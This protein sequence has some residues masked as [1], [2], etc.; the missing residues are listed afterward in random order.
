MAEIVI[1][2]VLALIVGEVY[3]RTKRPK[4]YALLNTAAGAGVLL[5]LQLAAKGE[6]CITGFNTALSG[7]LGIPG[8]VLCFIMDMW[9]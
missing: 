4:L 8:A 1:L 7:I 3:I 9:R 2:C 6:I 5:V